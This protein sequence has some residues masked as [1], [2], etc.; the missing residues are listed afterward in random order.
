MYLYLVNRYESVDIYHPNMPKKGDVIE[1][2]LVKARETGPAVHEDDKKQR[3]FFMG[4][5]RWYQGWFDDLLRVLTDYG[6]LTDGPPVLR[7]FP[8]MVDTVSLIFEKAA[9]KP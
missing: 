8:D 4:F 1:C 9:W 3:H 5:M 7:Q 6:K 2:M